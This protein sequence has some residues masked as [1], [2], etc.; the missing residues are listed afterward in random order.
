M[1]AHEEPGSVVAIATVRRLSSGIAYFS[2]QNHF[3]VTDAVYCFLNV[4]AWV[5]GG[6]VGDVI[7][8]GLAGYRGSW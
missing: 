4:V 5:H 6:L 1:L 7:T 8:L 3:D 2:S